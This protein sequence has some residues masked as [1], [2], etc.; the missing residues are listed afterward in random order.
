[1][2]VSLLLKYKYLQLNKHDTDP[3]FHQIFQSNT[4][5]CLIIFVFCKSCESICEPEITPLLHHLENQNKN[6]FMFSVQ[7]TNLFEE[8]MD[9]SHIYL[10]VQISNLKKEFLQII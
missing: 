5:V 1:M 9:L 7:F 3:D 2:S 8:N 6:N 4:S 10:P